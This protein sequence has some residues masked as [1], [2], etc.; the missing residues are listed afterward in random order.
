MTSILTNS[1]VANTMSALEL[2]A[3]QGDPWAQ[4][5]LQR[6]CMEFAVAMT[7]D[8]KAGADMTDRKNLT[9]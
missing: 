8:S 7:T 5:Q 2:R 1:K 6:Q 3:R 4:Q 9:N